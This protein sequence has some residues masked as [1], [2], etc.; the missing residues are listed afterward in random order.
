IDKVYSVP[1]FVR[2][3]ETL[4]ATAVKAFPGGKGLNQSLALKLAGGKV[5][6]AGKIGPDGAWLAELLFKQGVDTSFIDRS[7]E[8]TGTAV[9]QVDKSGQNC[10]LL[11]G[12][13]NYEITDEWIDKTLE[14]FGTGDLLVLQNEICG[15]PH[16][17][18]RAAERGI[19]IALN[20]SPIDDKLIHAG[21]DKI[22]YFLLNEIE[23]EA[24]S[25]KTDP[26]EICDVLLSRYPKAKIVLTLGRRGVYYRDAQTAA[27]HGI[28]SVPVVDTTAAGDTFTGF[29]LSSVSNGCEINEALRLA[30]VASSL[31]V[32]RNGAASSVPTLEEV[33]G[34]RLGYISEGVV[35]CK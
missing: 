26:V 14:N 22:T 35:P 10:I 3:G 12:G 20:P 5:Y 18:S 32:S 24:L 28:Y 8:A 19:T 30:S 21:L 13:A 33:R 23:G 15:L 27:S 16:I 4:S 1:H 25:G 31:A 9:I 29:F 11:Y 6:H 17:I 7:G 2:P 34:A